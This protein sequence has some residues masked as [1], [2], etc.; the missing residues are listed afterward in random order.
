MITASSLGVDQATLDRLIASGQ[1][2]QGCDLLDT[3]NRVV[4]DLTADMRAGGE[5][6]HDNFADAGQT[7]GKCQVQLM[8]A[9]AWG[10][11]RIRPWVSLSD[12]AAS[13]RINQGVYVLNTP[14]DAGGEDPATY[15]VLGYDLTSLLN[16]LVGDT[17]V[18]V[19]GTTYLDALRQV[20][21]D[22]GV[23]AQLLVDGSAQATPLPYTMVW[24]LY[25]GGPS[26]RAI[27][28]DL[29]RAIAYVPLWADENGALRSGPEVGVAQAPVGRR[30]TTTGPGSNVAKSPAWTR[31]EDLWAAPN[32][33]RFIRTNMA[34]APVDGDGI[35]EPPV[36]QS[37]GLSS[38][39]SVG[40]VRWKVVYLDAADQASLV[41]QG[42]QV[43]AEDMAAGQ[44]VTFSTFTPTASHG[45][46]VLFDGGGRSDK[47]PVASWVTN[48]D[49]MPGQWVAGGTRPEPPAPLS[50]SATG[51][52][53]QASTAGLRVV[54]D[55]ASQ[56]S[57]ANSLD[58]AAYT[59]GQ[60]VTLQVRNPVQPLVQGVETTD[61][62][63]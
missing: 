24:C 2:G 3:S 13:V 49:G 9:L 23:G 26:W 43:V 54:V 47:L 25:D 50:A 20:L 42:D 8:R 39:D 63:V 31:D 33:W 46:V 14:Q 40:R 5:I 55:G 1:V 30:F 37:T 29:L 17:R 51:T 52:V 62:G 18:V 34:T 35:Y 57:P 11:D 21:T 27:C 32:A 48:L 44:T 41:A 61:T 53:T 56:D 10:R 59:V 12:D 6:T 19:A 22:S 60:R 7:A 58:G 45:D 15:D 28:N 16:D 38:V 36:N 4:G